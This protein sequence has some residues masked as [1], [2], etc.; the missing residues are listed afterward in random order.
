METRPNVFDTSVTWGE[1]GPEV[2]AFGSGRAFDS[3]AAKENH[4]DVEEAI[5]RHI[6]AGARSFI[7]FPPPA[8]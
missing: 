8:A 3:V 7:D 1:E 5:R 2:E 4:A 6:G